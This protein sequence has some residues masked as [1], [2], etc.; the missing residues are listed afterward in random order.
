MFFIRCCLHK[1]SARGFLLQT[2]TMVVLWLIVNNISQL[3]MNF[4]V[5]CSISFWK[6]P[7]R[8]DFLFIVKSLFNQVGFSVFSYMFF[9]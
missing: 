2:L 3:V 4:L 5:V 1:V 6:F 8:F 7:A 9:I